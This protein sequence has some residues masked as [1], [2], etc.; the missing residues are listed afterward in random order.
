MLETILIIFSLIIIGIGAYFFYYFYK[1]PKPT[2]QKERK[3]DEFL[4]T[5]EYI[6]LKKENKHEP[7]LE[8]K[9]KCQNHDIDFSIGEIIA[10]KSENLD[11]DTLFQIL[12][13]CKIS[14]YRLKLDD[15]LKVHQS[16]LDKFEYIEIFIDLANSGINLPLSNY[17]EFAKKGFN[18]RK[19]A[20]AI[21]KSKTAEIDVNPNDIIKNNLDDVQAEK[22]VYALIRAKKANIFISEEDRLNLNLTIESDYRQSFKIT[23]SKLL[24][25][26]KAGKNIDIIVNAMIRAHESGVNV[27]PEA[28]DIHNITDKEFETLVN[29]LIK[30]HKN[31]IYIDQEDL[32]HQNI[33]GN[34]INKLVMAMLIVKKHNLE[35]EF[36]ELMDYHLLTS[37]DVLTFVNSII[38]ANNNDLGINKQYL[39]DMTVHGGDLIDLVNSVKI[40]DKYKQ[41]NIKRKDV[42]KHFK[43]KGR[44]F[45]V[46][47]YTIHSQA[48][49]LNLSFDLACEYDL[50][51]GYKL[52]D[53]IQM[54]LNPLTLD[55]DPPQTIVTKSGIQ[56]TPK[57]RITWRAKIEL[58]FTGHKEDVIFSRINEAL[59]TEI[60]QYNDHNDVL[61]NLTT[62]AGNV[63]KRIK[64]K[65]EIPKGASKELTKEIKDKNEIEQDIDANSAY[66]LIDLTIYDVEIGKDIK[67]D[68]EE[69]IHKLKNHHDE[70][71]AQIKMLE[72]EA[73]L[74]IS[75]AEA[76][77]K[78]EIPN[79][80]EIHKENI[81]KEKKKNPGHH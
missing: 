8:F 6:E 27:L 19:Y 81:F 45:E 51:D 60:E 67:N 24:E 30:A 20:N 21:I 18:A 78:G 69:K 57:L 76:Y 23:K 1:T 63:L 31:G 39:I 28:L 53:L 26:H 74:K 5:K 56:V 48:Q 70:L 43:K 32:L 14:D 25:L 54:A 73:E 75:M 66:D 71:H 22:F 15:L 35:L 13:K 3:I 36:S 72:A 12:L 46:I 77:K 29:N 38:V 2:R 16:G 62:I 52:I 65:I 47:K 37:G 11:F 17:I 7:I 79:F 58:L 55:V 49:G 4:F 59:I 61:N 9:I 10:A 44:V 68:I 50:I 42:E 41:F 64:G 33:S 34:D 80:N 40:L